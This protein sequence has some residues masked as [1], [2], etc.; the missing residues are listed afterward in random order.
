MGAAALGPA[1]EGL[2]FAFAAIA[3]AL[4]AYTLIINPLRSGASAAAPI[5]LI[6]GAIS[7]VLINLAELCVQAVQWVNQQID[8]GKA[9]AASWW[10]WMVVATI[11]AYYGD[12]NGWI[13]W[14]HSHVDDL[15]AQSFGAIPQQLAAVWSW[16]NYLRT[17]ADNTARWESTVATQ[18]IPNI[19]A[20]INYLNTA[21]SSVN[22][23]VATLEMQT[24]P[25]L[26]AWINY[27]QA[28]SVAVRQ[29]EST[30]GDV[31]LP[32]LQADVNGRAH[33]WEAEALRQALRE[34]Q[35]S[36][37]ILIPLAV[38]AAAGAEAVSNLRCHM[39]IPC[40]PLSVLASANVDDRLTHLE[41]SEG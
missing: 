5:P 8:A 41:I 2:A 20:W 18:T 33:E 13:A 34:A 21:M 16:I 28:L 15:W 4:V 24:V 9:Q 14:L 30:V 39:D 31:V 37:A 22:A 26:Y 36:I 25:N 29:W 32:R 17:I 38:I 10:N 11:S 12:L 1:F 19:Y 7:W 27:L 3:F 35:R 23:Q 40:D 6:G